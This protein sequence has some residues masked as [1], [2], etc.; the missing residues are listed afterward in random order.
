MSSVRKARTCCSECGLW[1]HWPRCTQQV[2]LA[3]CRGVHRSTRASGVLSKR[4]LA[5]HKDHGEDKVY[6][7]YRLHSQSII[8]KVRLELTQRPW[9]STACWLTHQALPSLPA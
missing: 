8:R 7:V 6:L 9:R 3:A 2:S 5:L 4:F 1:S